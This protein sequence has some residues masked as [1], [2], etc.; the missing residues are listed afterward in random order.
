[1][2]LLS[3]ICL[4]VFASLLSAAEPEGFLAIDA[5]IGREEA[6][7]GQSVDYKIR[8]TGENLSDV[9]I[10]LPDKR[11]VYADTG[12]EEANG[13]AIVPIYIIDSAKKEENFDSPTQT[14]LITMDVRFY[15]PGTWMLPEVDITGAD[16]IKAGYRI[17]SVTVS[18]L[19]PSGEF[20]ESEPPLQAPGSNMRIFVFVLLLLALAVLFVILWRRRKKNTEAVIPPESPFDIFMNEL[21]QLDGI[22]LIKQGK[23][24]EYTFGIS[25]IFR[26]FLSGQ[27][28]FEA[29]E[30]TSG[31]LSRH[32]VRVFRSARYAGLADEITD[33]FKL[34]DLAKFAEFMPTEDTMLRS[35]ENIIKIVKRLI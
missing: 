29:A 28:M 12:G 10:S 19:N 34:W 1:M 17:P 24:E 13:Q 33:Q 5:T 18:A 22:T 16:G 15:Q 8:I 35:H 30:M 11:Q 14:V 2:K 31:E 3:V 7:V 27:F 25:N 20:Q 9:N 6:A 26:R 4:M 23:I 21:E 32:L